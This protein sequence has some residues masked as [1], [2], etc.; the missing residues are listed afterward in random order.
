MGEDGQDFGF[1]FLW[2]V[3]DLMSWKL[4]QVEKCVCGVSGVS[5]GEF[6]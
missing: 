3:G 6:S 1:I 2:F 5:G 4:K